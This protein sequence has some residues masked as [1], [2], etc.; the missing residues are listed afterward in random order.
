MR[1]PDALRARTQASISERA[2]DAD[3]RLYRRHGAFLLAAWRHAG[4]PAR[5]DRTQHGAALR[6][7]LLIRPAEEL[8]T[9]HA[10]SKAVR[11]IRAGASPA[12]LSS[13]LENSGFLDALL[14]E[15]AGGIGLGPAEASP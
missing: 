1:A 12:G 8:F 14:P 11:A 2:A 3:A 9:R 10:S 6:D 5:H 15:A 4:D 13:E 7:S